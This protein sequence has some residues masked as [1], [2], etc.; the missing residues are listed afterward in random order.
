MN[1]LSK[2]FSPLSLLS[3]IVELIEKYF[4]K[5]HHMN[6]ELCDCIEILRESE[7]EREF[8]LNNTYI[9][10]YKFLLC[11]KYYIDNISN[12]YIFYFIILVDY[13]AH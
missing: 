13:I 10:K 3:S 5:T 6:Y 2:I 1:N 4:K 8:K 11:N 9:I 7:R 12:L